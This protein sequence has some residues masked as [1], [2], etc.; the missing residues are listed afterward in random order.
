MSFVVQ[1]RSTNSLF[2]RITFV[3]YLVN[4]SVFLSRL[5]IIIR[6]DIKF[7]IQGKHNKAISLL[8]AASSIRRKKLG[9]IH[10]STVDIQISLER[11]RKHIR[12][13]ETN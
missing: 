1:F 4:E 7:R 5:H 6:I 3:F 9:E 2:H 13:R 12:E 8:E 11:V 10:H